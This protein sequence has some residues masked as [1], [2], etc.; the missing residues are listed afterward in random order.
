MKNEDFILTGSGTKDP[1]LTPDE[2]AFCESV[3]VAEMCVAC[4]GIL[5]EDAGAL[6]KEAW[7]M[8]MAVQDLDAIPTAVS[9]VALSNKIAAMRA[10]MQRYLD[11]IQ[12]RDSDTSRSRANAS[13]H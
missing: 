13:Q 1:V 7:R 2:L 4:L 11:P 3:A 8:S 9:A 6:A 5:E 10:D 12:Q